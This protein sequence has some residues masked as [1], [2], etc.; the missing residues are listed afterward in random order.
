[1]TTRR[2]SR[3]SFAEKS[4]VQFGDCSFEVDLLD[5]SLKGALVRF[6]NAVDCRQGDRWRLSFQLGDSDIVMQFTTEVAHA[7]DNLVGVKFIET[8]L[9]TMIHLRNLMEARTM[10]P[11][12]VR[13]ELDYLVDKDQ[14]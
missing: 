9:D 6:G 11:E 3:V 5:I 8:D 2:F 7:R 12:Q 14:Q 13:S 4:I 10:D 1:M